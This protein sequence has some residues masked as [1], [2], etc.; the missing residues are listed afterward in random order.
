VRKPEF[1]GNKIYLKYEELEADFAKQ[2]F[3]PAHL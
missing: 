2:V 3:Q 1:G